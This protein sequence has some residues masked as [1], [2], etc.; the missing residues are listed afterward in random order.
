MNREAIESK[1]VEIIAEQLG[2]EVEEVSL[3]ANIRDDFDADSLDMV[4]I[5]MSCEDE[6]SVEFPEDSMDNLVYVKDV[7]DFIEKNM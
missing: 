7:V 1:L 5:V 6:F 4:D 2:L 3:D